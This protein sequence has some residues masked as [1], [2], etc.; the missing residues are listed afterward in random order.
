[1]TSKIDPTIPV[2]G[3]GVMSAPIR[4]NFQAAY[5]EITAL[6]Q[7]GGGGGPGTPGPT[8]ATGPT[9]PTGPPGPTGPAGGGTGAGATGPTGPSGPPGAQGPSGPAGPAGVPVAV[10]TSAPSPA[11]PGMLWFDTSA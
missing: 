7:G 11:T 9:G 8:G 5:D 4:Q 10:G 3:S 2:A 1:M 6:Q